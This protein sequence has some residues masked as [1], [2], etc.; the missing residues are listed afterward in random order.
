MK[1][2]A[3]RFL[4]STPVVMFFSMICFCA[5]TVVAAQ[6]FQLL[7]PLIDQVVSDP[8]DLPKGAKRERFTLKLYLSGIDCGYWVGGLLVITLVRKIIVGLSTKEYST[9]LAFV[10]FVP[11]LMSLSQH[12]D[13]QHMVWIML[14]IYCIYNTTFMLLTVIGL[15]KALSSLFVDQI[16][17]FVE[18]PSEGTSESEEACSEEKDLCPC[19]WD[20]RTAFMVKG[21]RH[22]VACRV[23]RSRLIYRQ[24]KL[25]AEASVTL[26][27][28]PRMRLLTEKHLQE[29]KVKCPLCRQ[30]DFIVPVA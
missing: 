20:A 28:V 6:T 15:M 26:R 11:T 3:L 24:L 2:P 27:P 10:F 8:P 29:T 30:L 17:D 1:V 9:V 13:K 23:C 21:C 16:V 14:P 18:M 22:P 4:T 5:V 7:L 12:P 19:C 25:D